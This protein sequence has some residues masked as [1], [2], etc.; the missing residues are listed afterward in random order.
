MIASPDLPAERQVLIP[1]TITSRSLTR[2]RRDAYVAQLGGATMG[3]TWSAQ[4]AVSASVSLPEI[5]RRIVR[6]LDRI[7][8]Q[9]STWEAGSEIS[10]F[11]RAPAGT[12]HEIGDEFMTVLAA[13]LDVAQQTAGAYDPTVG[14]IVD[15]WGFGPSRIA[16]GAPSAQT[17]S[18]A[19]ACAGWQRV[20]ADRADRRVLQVGGVRLD[21]SSIAKGFAVDQV[22]SYLLREGVTDFLVE[23]GGELRGAGVKPD[24]TPWWV[25]LETPPLSDEA[26]LPAETIVALHG[27]SIATSGDYRRFR[28]VGGKRVAHTIDPRTGRPVENEIASVTVIAKQCMMADAWATAITVL[29]REAGSALAERNGLAA[30]IVTQEAGRLVQHLSP[31]MAAMLG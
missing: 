11:N 14:E 3:T 15:L 28:E 24:G 25:L 23:V 9:M 21:L 29:G 4:L 6:E 2:P 31:K 17:L 26:G 12:W 10:R 16:D 22:A 27:L 30:L 19:A 8:A 18:A 20:F 5:E 13:A 1:R 7:I